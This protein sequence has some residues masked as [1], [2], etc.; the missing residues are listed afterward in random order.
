M[1]LE[2]KVERRSMIETEGKAQSQPCTNYQNNP[3]EKARTERIRLL[4][5][6]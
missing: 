4:N 1:M 2:N 3:N 5:H 6:L